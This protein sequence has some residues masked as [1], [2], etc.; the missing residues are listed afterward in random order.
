MM[1]LNWIDYVFIA[2]F[3]LSIFAGVSRGFIREM[4]SLITFAAAIVIAVM[5][6]NTLA[7][8]FT[9]DPSVQNVVSQSSSTIGVDTTQTVSYLAIGVSFVVLFVGT[10]IV[11]AIV[12]YIVN[13]AFQTGVL[14]FGNR[15]LGAI[16]GFGRAF[17][18]N[19]VLIF[20]VQLTSLADKDAWH[21]SVVVSGYQP[22]VVWLTG[23]VSP[24]LASLKE[25][26]QAT[27]QGVGSQV[28]IQMQN[29][30]DTLQQ[31]QQQDQ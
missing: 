15:V 27:L 8:A 23:V 28:Q 22:M 16:F 3:L 1:G 30:A 14:G 25:K 4:M 26:L 29:G 20:L 12:G 7:L 24:S 6:A 18:I 19:L 2:I 13:M 10:I 5:F 31:H 11:G 17:I 21:A 9:G